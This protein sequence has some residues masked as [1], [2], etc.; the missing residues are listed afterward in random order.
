MAKKNKPTP[1]KSKAEKV[2]KAKSTPKKTVE[3]VV[4]KKSKPVAPKKVA[5]KVSKP[6]KKVVKKVKVVTKE[7]KVAV[8]KVKVEKVE[9]VKEKAIKKE[10]TVAPKIEKEV[11]PKLAKEKKIKVIKAPK[12]AITVAKEK[13][14]TVETAL[15]DEKKLDFERIFDVK[16]GTKLLFNSLNIGG[17]VKIRRT[18]SFRYEITG[19][20]TD[21]VTPFVYPFD[22]NPKSDDGDVLWQDLLNYE[23]AVKSGA[24]TKKVAESPKPVEKEAKKE[25]I[26]P[27][28]I[29]APIVTPT[30][31]VAETVNPVS[32]NDAIVAKMQGYG[33]SIADTINNTF[34][35]KVQGAIAQGDVQRLLNASSKEYTYE[36]KAD[37]NGRYIVLTQGANSIRVPQDETAYLP[38]N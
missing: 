33:N 16:G 17:D 3:K 31:V 12:E 37:Q 23:K 29:E 6:E 27:K 13:E 26:T 32:D 25:A 14:K 8:P 35:V 19:L 15:A 22:C 34:Q 4:V 2:V 5:K 21:G 24:D 9:V 10:K 20:M 7:V 11:A 28:P 1:S 18:E 30:P 36:I 38:I